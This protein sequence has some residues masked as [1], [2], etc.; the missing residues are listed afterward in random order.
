MKDLQIE[1]TRIINSNY[2]RYD[3]LNEIIPMSTLV[4]SSS[5]TTMFYIDLNSVLKPIYQ[6]NVLI[7]D[8]EAITSCIINMCAHYREYFWTRYK[9]NAVFF[10]VYSNNTPSFN[11]LMYPDYNNNMKFLLSANK[12]K[13]S[14]VENN[15]KLLSLLSPYLPDIFFINREFE[16]GVI[17]Q[18]LID[19]YDA[20][21]RYTHIVLTKDV[22]NYQLVGNNN[23][24]VVIL[25]PSKKNGMDESIIIDR[26]NLIN[27]YLNKRKSSYNLSININPSL[28]SLIMSMS[29]LSERSIKSNLNISKTL[30]YIEEMIKNNIIINDYNSYTMNIWEYISKYEKDL[31]PII[32]SNRFKCID[33]YSQVLVYRTLNQSY[34]EIV[35]MSDPN[36]LKMINDRYFIKNP[37]DLD[38]L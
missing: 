33:I 31:S 2:V 27:I 9:V 8:Y 26:N 34:P 4:Q 11:T 32:L 13:Y 38:R 17:I 21:S 20:D 29:S 30:K 37:L 5:D 6:E 36:S 22:Y 24:N 1:M 35:N 25:K 10:I 3:R 15:F 19:I 7:D 14:I 28:L 16:T 12:L 18:D 23:K